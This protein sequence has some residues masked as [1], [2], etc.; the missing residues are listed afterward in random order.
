MLAGGYLIPEMLHLLLRAFDC[1][2]L[3]FNQRASVPRYAGTQNSL[4][5]STRRIFTCFARADN[6]AHIMGHRPC[7]A[8]PPTVKRCD[9]AARILRA[10]ALALD[11]F[12]Q[13]LRKL[14]S[15]DR[16]IRKYR[17]Q[18]RCR[19]LSYRR[20]IAELPVQTDLNQLV[21][22]AYDLFI[23]GFHDVSSLQFADRRRAR[24]ERNSVSAARA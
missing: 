2:P 10:S 4:I 15:T 18:L 7:Q 6:R 20:P 13:F 24:Q 23:C 17:S 9:E 16:V 19:Y 22:V 14:R 8:D 21:Q 1:F 5:A 11:F 12:S 3:A